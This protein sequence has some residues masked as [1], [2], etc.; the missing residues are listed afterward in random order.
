MTHFEVLFNGYSDT[1]KRLEEDL[2]GL[3]LPS[4]GKVRVRE[5]KMYDFVVN[6]RSRD[7]FISVLKSFGARFEDNKTNYENAKHWE[8]ESEW[9]IDRTPTLSNLRKK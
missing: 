3:V 8:T 1:A 9:S 2:N 5:W 4:G 6:E 7:E